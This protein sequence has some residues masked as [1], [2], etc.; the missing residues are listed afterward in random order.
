MHASQAVDAVAVPLP[1]FA[2][3]GFFAAWFAT[4]LLI[5]HHQRVL[6]EHRGLKARPGAHIGANLLAGH[7]RQ[8]I[9][10]GGQD[11]DRAVD[12]AGGFANEELAEQRRGVN[13]V[14]APG[15]AGQEGDGQPNGVFADLPDRLLERIVLLVQAH[16]SV[17]VSLDQALDP[18]EKIGP[19]GLRAG[20]STPNPPGHRGGEKQTNRGQHQQPG[21]VINFLRPDLDEKEVGPGVGQVGEDRLVGRIGAAIPANERSQVVDGQ[22]NGQGR[23]FNSPKPSG[24]LSRIN[25]LPAGV[26]AGPCGLAVVCR[27]GD[28]LV[29]H[30]RY[31]SSGQAGHM[32]QDTHRG[33]RL[34]LPM[35]S[36]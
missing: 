8:E 21:Q 28:R 16:P 2:S 20:V 36:M 17:A 9:G 1:A 35:L 19:D 7:S 6:V 10:G 24:D 3:L 22:Q 13:E 15:A 11:D 4:P 30:C 12:H 27:R 32:Q 5:G 29:G 14:Q 34:A 18:H 31:F 23:P 33:T 25:L 26:E